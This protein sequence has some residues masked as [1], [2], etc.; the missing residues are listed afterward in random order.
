MTLDA[1]EAKI[2]EYLKDGPRA[3]GEILRHLEWS[4]GWT[5]E[6]TLRRKLMGLSK[7]GLATPDKWR[8]SKRGREAAKGVE[9]CSK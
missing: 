7:R 4:P 8:L 1:T 3:I 6:G 2:V 9:K 5:S